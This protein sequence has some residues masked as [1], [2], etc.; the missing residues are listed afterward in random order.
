M[1]LKNKS[2][3]GG[4]LLMAANIYRRQNLTTKFEDWL[5]EKCGI[6]RQTSYNYRNLQKLMS[7]APKLMN[8]WVNNTFF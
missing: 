7:D 8:C 6:K 2:L 4:W 3:I 1:G 5:N